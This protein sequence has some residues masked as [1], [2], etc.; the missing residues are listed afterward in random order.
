MTR[1]ERGEVYE[2][3]DIPWF[4]QPVLD[5]VRL[6]IELLIF[7]LKKVYEI[8]NGERERALKSKKWERSSICFL[9]L[10]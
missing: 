5:K 9:L 7:S 1:A 8:S 4:W 10:L 6:E 2:N 3:E